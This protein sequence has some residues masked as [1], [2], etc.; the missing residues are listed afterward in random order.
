MLATELSDELWSIAAVVGS[1]AVLIL[2][3]VAGRHIKRMSI[4]MKGVKFT[5]D[6]ELPQLKKTTEDISQSVNHR[7]PH[8]PT[9]VQRVVNV[10]A[11]L[12]EM[13]R[14]QAVIRQTQDDH[15]K[16]TKEWQDKLVE[17]IGVEVRIISREQTE[18]ERTKS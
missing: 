2:C 4:D 13:K 8:E 12:K 18:T 16:I 1:V 14:V 5:V 9:L 3:V 15:I 17:A 6:T 11:G 7:A 10:E